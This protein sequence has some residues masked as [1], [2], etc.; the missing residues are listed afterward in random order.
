MPILAKNKWH[1]KKSST[2]HGNSLNMQHND[3][4][5]RKEKKCYVVMIAKDERN[6]YSKFELVLH[7]W[8]KMNDE[9]VT[10]RFGWWMK[11]MDGDHNIHYLA[12]ELCYNFLLGAPKLNIFAFDSLL[13]HN[14]MES[15]CWI[16]WK[17]ASIRLGIATKYPINFVIIIFCIIFLMQIILW[18]T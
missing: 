3:H 16:C 5:G 6:M 14:Y 13:H 9:D 2:T 10:S 7:H 1:T 15:L 17:L 4:K 8:V 11:K 12:N 18:C